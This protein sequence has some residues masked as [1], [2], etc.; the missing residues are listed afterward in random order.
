MYRPTGPGRPACR[1]GSTSQVLL[2]VLLI[3][4][5]A[6]AVAVSTREFVTS[7]GDPGP[8]AEGMHLQCLKCKHEFIR[9][10]KEMTLG[11]LN[12]PEARL[13]LDC[14]NC[15]GKRS[16][17]PMMECP[18]CKKYFVPASYLQPGGRARDVCT[19]C[20]TDRAAWWAEYYDKHK[21]P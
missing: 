8:S 17:V 6:V 21:P 20:G 2:I 18:K 3:A 13:R 5:I 11:E 15:G 9:T 10:G 12:T 16:A 1:A 14:P 7:P 19:H 4:V